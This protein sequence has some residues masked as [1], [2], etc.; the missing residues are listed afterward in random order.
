MYKYVIFQILKIEYLYYDCFVHIIILTSINIYNLYISQLYIFFISYYLIIIL[1]AL[2]DFVCDFYLIKNIN[3]ESI[4][5][6]TYKIKFHFFYY[7]IFQYFFSL[8][9]LLQIRL[10]RNCNFRIVI[11]QVF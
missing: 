8:F 9:A 5:N 7:F 3:D 6:L 10:D 11:F 2:I 4:I 1:S